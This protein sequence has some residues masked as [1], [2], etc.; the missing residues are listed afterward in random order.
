MLLFV[1]V[2]VVVV[3]DVEESGPPDWE[4]QE[5]GMRVGFGL[6][7]SEARKECWAA[8]FEKQG[9]KRVGLGNKGEEWA[10]SQNGPP[11]LALYVCLLF[12]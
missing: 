6:V 12:L 10:A 1:A 2:V 9:R 7:F 4:R 8:G 3:V 5:K 11:A